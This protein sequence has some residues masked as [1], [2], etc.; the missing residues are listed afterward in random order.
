MPK[1]CGKRGCEREAANTLRF[2]DPIRIDLDSDHPG[3]L[4]EEHTQEVKQF[5]ETDAKVVKQWLEMG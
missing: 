1:K 2:P 5:P 4:C 3:M